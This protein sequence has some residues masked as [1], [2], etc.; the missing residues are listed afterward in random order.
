MGQQVWFIWED[1]GGEGP[2][3][4]SSYYPEHRMKILR[5]IKMTL[6]QDRKLPGWDSNWAYPESN[7]KIGHFRELS[8]YFAVRKARRLISDKK[9]LYSAHLH[10]VGVVSHLWVL[11]N[12]SI[13]LDYYLMY[14]DS[15]NLK[16]T[17]LLSKESW[18]H[19]TNRQPHL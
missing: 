12:T 11:Q 5:K 1:R 8:M 14:F 7:I 4:N 15:R 19:C 18:W 9:T 2:S 16:W 17:S 10:V 3:P 6:G 13:R